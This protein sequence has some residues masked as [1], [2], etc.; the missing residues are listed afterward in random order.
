MPEKGIMMPKVGIIAKSVK[1]SAL[2]ALFSFTQQR[3][4]G[5]LFGQPARAFTIS[6]LISLTGAGSGGVQREMKR[7]LESGFIEL[8]RAGRDKRYRANARGFLFTE[9]KSIVDKTIGI[10]TTLRTLVEG[11]GQDISL[12]VLFGSVAKSTDTS[13]SDIDVLVV[14][15][16]LSLAAALKLF[17]VAEGQL[18]RQISPTIYSRS[19]FQKTRDAPFL[20]KLFAGEHVVLIGDPDE[21]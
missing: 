13:T 6:E 12:A 7:L 4:L 17:A 18:G 9:L 21:V 20:S 5:L 2:D 10:A 1:R 11:A 15:D 16:T 8:I 14:S 3:V 19:E